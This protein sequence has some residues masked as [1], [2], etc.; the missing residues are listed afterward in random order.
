MRAQRILRL[1][2]GLTLQQAAD[3]FLVQLNSVEQW[4][5]RCNKS[6]LVRLYEVHHI[7]WLCKWTPQQRHPL[8][9]SAQA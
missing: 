2:Q 8:G 1:S 3:E 4:R 9:E 5:Q 7:E 6:G